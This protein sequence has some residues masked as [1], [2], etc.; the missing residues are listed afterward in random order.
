MNIK[1]LPTFDFLKTTFN[2]NVLLVKFPKEAS[3]RMSIE[4][5]L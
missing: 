5:Q 2:E 4:V 3:K 1:A